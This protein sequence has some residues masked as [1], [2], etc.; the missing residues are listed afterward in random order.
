[1]DKLFDSFSWKDIYQYWKSNTTEEINIVNQPLLCCKVHVESNE[2]NRVYHH[3]W[4]KKE[5]LYNFVNKFNKIN[6]TLVFHKRELDDTSVSRSAELFV[7]SRSEEERVAIWIFVFCNVL[8]KQDLIYPNGKMID[9][10]GAKSR[11]F[12]QEYFQEWQFRY[13]HQFP[14]MFINS[15]QINNLTLAN[16]K[17]VIDLAITNAYIICK[18]YVVTLFDSE[19]E[20]EEPPYTYRNLRKQ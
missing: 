13:S 14:K 19:P 3:F 1:M 6:N 12:L 16:Y 5:D 7:Q 10:V 20:K 8:G 17:A 11:L 9:Y 4:M 2:D 18:E 15:Q